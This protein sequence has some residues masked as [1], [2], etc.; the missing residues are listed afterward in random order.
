MRVPTGARRG[1]SSGEREGGRPGALLGCP[2]L[3]PLGVWCLA[4]LLCR[5]LAM[6]CDASPLPRLIM[7]AR[8]NSR[9]DGLPA[10]VGSRAEHGTAQLLASAPGNFL[11]VTLRCTGAARTQIAAQLSP[12]YSLVQMRSDLFVTL[13][14]LYV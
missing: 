9:A 11:Q 10:H 7:L 13:G 3:G 12:Q 1:G 8:K 5:V 14:V 2:R 4:L 6:R